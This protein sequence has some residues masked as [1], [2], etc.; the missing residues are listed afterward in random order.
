MTEKDNNELFRTLMDVVKQVQRYGFASRAQQPENGHRHSYG[1]ARLLK[2]IA[3]HDNVTQS[4]LAEL[5]DVRPSSLSEMLS[6]LA[7][8]ELIERQTDEN[9]K[10]VTH[11]VLTDKGKAVLAER[12]DAADDYLATIFAGLS[13]EETVQLTQLLGKVNGSLKDRLADMDA[14]E[15]PDFTKFG[16]ARSH[17]G[18]GRFNHPDGAGFDRRGF[19]P[20]GHGF[21]N[22]M[23]N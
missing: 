20:D 5:M 2:L 6:K 19:R 1:R 10:R 3:D 7:E 18:H 9:D 8:R 15:E 21:H 12:Q 14:P 17:F 13:D 11:V 4:E 23:W 16:G 22:S